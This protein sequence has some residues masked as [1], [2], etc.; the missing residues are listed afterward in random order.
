MPN[1]F[2][3]FKNTNDEKFKTEMYGIF[4]RAH[5]AAMDER[6]KNEV[7]GGSEVAEHLDPMLLEQLQEMKPFIQD[8]YEA[9]REKVDAWL[10]ENEK[11]EDQLK[12]GIFQNT[13]LSILDR[14][15]LER[16][17]QA[18]DHYLKYLIQKNKEDPDSDKT[19]IPIVT[20]AY[21]LSAPTFRGIPKERIDAFHDYLKQNKSTLVGQSADSG[22]IVFCKGLGVLAAG[23]ILPVAGGIWAY[24][25]LFQKQIE[26]EGFL[27]SV[28]KPEVRSPSKGPGNS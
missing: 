4:N 2:E 3:L 18:C 23:I 5:Q 10:P 15:Q 28:D 21:H 19:L 20:Q 14:Y 24:N 1:W 13:L 16:Y 22:F 7:V 27:Q 26:R 8:H 12:C 25:R 11:P 9:F 6:K 17:H